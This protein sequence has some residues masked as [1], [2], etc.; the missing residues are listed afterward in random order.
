M[1]RLLREVNR[2]QVPM[3]GITDLCFCEY[4]SHGHCGPLSA[5]GTTVLPF[6]RVFVVARR[7]RA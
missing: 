2:Q 1:C 3:V 6:R 4:T 7:T 5:D